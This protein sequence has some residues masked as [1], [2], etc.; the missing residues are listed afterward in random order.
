MVNLD[1]LTCSRLEQYISHTKKGRLVLWKARIS[2]SLLLHSLQELNRK[3]KL[4]FSKGLWD[5]QAGATAGM[6][7]VRNGPGG[8]KVKWS[9]QMYTVICK[10][11]IFSQEGARRPRS[12]GCLWIPLASVP[13]RPPTEKPRLWAAPGA[14][15]LPWKPQDHKII[16]KWKRPPPPKSS[17]PTVPL[18][19]ILWCW[20]KGWVTEGMISSWGSTKARE[21]QTS[22]SIYNDV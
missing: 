13:S 1:Y 12:K 22:Q 2:C 5:Q 16:K 15:A 21:K 11:H 10:E 3:W 17:S 8:K 20:A 19:P 6:R 14:R 18:P 4:V 9:F 7:R